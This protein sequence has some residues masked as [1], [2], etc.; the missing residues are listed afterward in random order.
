MEIDLLD[1]IEIAQ[2]G[3][4]FREKNFPRKFFNEITERIHFLLGKS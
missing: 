2:H 3:E 4:N 1:L